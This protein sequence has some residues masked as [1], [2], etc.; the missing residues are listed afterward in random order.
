DEEVRSK[1]HHIVAGSKNNTDHQEDDRKRKEGFMMIKITKFNLNHRENPFPPF[2]FPPDDLCCFCYQPRGDVSSSPPPLPVAIIPPINMHSDREVTYS[3]QARDG[4]GTF[5]YN[6]EV[7]EVARKQILIWHKNNVFFRSPEIAPSDRHDF[8][9]VAS[10][11]QDEGSDR[12]D[13]DFE[14]WKSV[15]IPGQ[16]ASYLVIFFLSCSLIVAIYLDA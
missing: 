4:C 8:R 11:Q 6:E 1:K 10:Y 5:M 13:F 14:A 15:F 12:R 2:D 16:I 9:T 3:A 7:C